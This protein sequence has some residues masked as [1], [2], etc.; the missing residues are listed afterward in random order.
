MLHWAHLTRSH[1]KILPPLNTPTS[2]D[3]H[4]CGI[5]LWISPQWRTCNCYDITAATLPPATNV[6]AVR[7]PSY[8]LHIVNLWQK[9]LLLERPVQNWCYKDATLHIAQGIFRMIS[10]IDSSE[11]CVVNNL[12]PQSRHS[13]DRCWNHTVIRYP[14]SVIISCSPPLVR[15]FLNI[16]MVFREKI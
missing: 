14:A 16:K 9:Y 7:Q 12:V 8:T 10:E 11:W 2:R 15:Q 3:S 13:A 1:L 5:I 6:G 4:S